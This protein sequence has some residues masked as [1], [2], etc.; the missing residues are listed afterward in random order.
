MHLPSSSLA[1]SF[2]LIRSSS[3]SWI[4]VILIVDGKPDETFEHMTVLLYMNQN[5]LTVSLTVLSVSCS[6]DKATP[7]QQPPPPH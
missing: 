7:Q 4:L 6:I 5:H 1:F 3:V 2:L